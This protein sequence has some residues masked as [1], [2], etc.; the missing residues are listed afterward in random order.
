VMRTGIGQLADLDSGLAG[1]LQTQFVVELLDHHTR[2]GISDDDQIRGTV[3]IVVFVDVDA[4]TLLQLAGG[5]HHF[6]GQLT[7]LVIRASQRAVGRFI[8]QQ[9]HKPIIAAGQ[10]PPAEPVQCRKA[11]LRL[12][13]IE[14]ER[15]AF[16]PTRRAERVMAVGSPQDQHAVGRG[17]PG[18]RS[19]GERRTGQR[20]WSA[21]AIEY[22]AQGQ[23]VGLLGICFWREPSETAIGTDRPACRSLGEDWRAGKW[24]L[25]GK[26]GFG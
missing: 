2:Y 6:D 4:G 11:L 21:R 12:E 3:G 1:Y 10:R 19:E 8:G 24:G 25:R 16:I 9:R 5:E 13:F 22:P 15:L 17:W 26:R 7:G 18:W 14:L 20:V 23:R